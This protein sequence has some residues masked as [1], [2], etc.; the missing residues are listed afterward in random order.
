ME[1]QSGTRDMVA[2]MKE[3]CPRIFK[4][5]QTAKRLGSLP[6]SSGAETL[7]QRIH[8]QQE[9]CRNCDGVHCGQPTRGFYPCLING[10]E[11]MVMCRYEGPR[12]QQEKIQRLVKAAGLPPYLAGK[13]WAD[14]KAYDSDAAKAKKMGQYMGRE[15]LK[16]GLFISGPKGTGKT[17]L[18][19]LIARDRLQAGQPTLFV[20]VPELMAAFRQGIKDGNEGEILQTAKDAVILVMDDIGAERPTEYAAERIMDLVNYRYSHC[21]A[22]IFTSNYGLDELARHLSGRGGDPVIGERIVS[23]IAGMTYALR[24][25]GQDQRIGY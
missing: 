21:L 23:R 20:F 18:A 8:E 1:K 5:L 24:L 11:T 22:T 4:K 12:R 13:T 25:N 7:A 17:F 3:Y 10:H 6:K 15:G 14:Y 16:S 9:P 2:A 19:A